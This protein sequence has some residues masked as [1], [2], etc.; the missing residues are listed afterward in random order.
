MGKNARD[1]RPNLKPVTKIELSEKN[2]TLRFVL[3]IVLLAIAAVSFTVFL[4]GLLNKD[5]GWNVIDPSTKE[6]IYTSEIQL[7][8]RL[9]AGEANATVEHKAIQKL[10]TEKLLEAYK[11]FSAYEEFSGVVNLKKLTTSTNSKQI[12][13]SLLYNTLKTMTENGN[14]ILYY[15]PVFSLYSNL[16]GSEDDVIAEMHDP[17]KDY[18]LRRDLGRLLPYVMSDEHIRLEFLDD[19][20]HEIKLFISEE[21]F[22]L[23]SE[24]Y[25]DSYISL[26]IFEMAFVVDYVADALGASGYNNG[27]VT[28]YNG[29]T[30]NLGMEQEIISANIQQATDNQKVKTVAQYTYTGALSMVAFR[31]YPITGLDNL[32]YYVYEDGTVV[33]P[34]INLNTGLNETLALD[35]MIFYSKNTSC[36]K[37]ALMSYSFFANA[38]L[39]GE[40][41]NGL[42]SSGIYAIYVIDDI[43]FY[44]DSTLISDSKLKVLLSGYNK[45]YLFN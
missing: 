29:Y 4:F 7:N 38:S 3:L 5:K 43:V 26:G 15:A 14:R 10:Y 23:L 41:I 20:K 37:L 28:S 21:Y 32:N 16:F 35:D 34:H 13:S 11:T 27:I 44:N 39:L 12:V 19:E 31:N 24:L 40:D 30:R 22:S 45:S 25:I 18:E 6:D 8:Y 2:T 17:H 9:G 1:K 42:T 36:A 33:S